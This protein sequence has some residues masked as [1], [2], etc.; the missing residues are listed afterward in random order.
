[1]PARNNRAETRAAR[2]LAKTAGISYMQ[3]L[4]RVRARAETDLSGLD[5]AQLAQRIAA[6]LDLLTDSNPDAAEQFQ[7]RFSTALDAIDDGTADRIARPELAH[8]AER[9]HELTA[10]AAPGAVA[11]MPSRARELCPHCRRP[12]NPSHDSDQ[13]EHCAHNLWD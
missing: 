13:C 6:E 8:M 9:L 3:A 10:A 7:A 2:Q 12:L 11:L 4:E 1:M 5:P